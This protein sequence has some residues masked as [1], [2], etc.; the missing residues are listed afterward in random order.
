MRSLTTLLLLAGLASAQAADDTAGMFRRK[1][2]AV[3]R[4][5]AKAHLAMGTF[6]D[7]LRLFAAG[8]HDYLRAAQLDPSNAEAQAALGRKLVDGQWV[9]D[10]RVPAIVVNDL[11]SD[12][13][14]AMLAKYR[15]KKRV[16]GSEVAADYEKLADLAVDWGLTVEARAMWETMLRYEPNNPRAQAKLGYRKMAG[17]WISAAEGDARDAM[18]KRVL[19]APGG[20]VI[21]ATSE[22]EEK[23]GWTMAKRRTE[24]FSFEGQ[25]T[26]GE[27][28]ALVRTAETTR[29]LFLEAFD[30]PKE[31][32][33]PFLT[34]ILVR[35]QGDHRTF[36]EKCTEA[37]ELE[38]KAAEDLP[39]WEDRDPE[40]VE[41]WLGERPFDVL[42]DEVVH[43]VARSEFRDLAR[44]EK[45]PAWLAEG[46]A[47]WFGD[48]IL[49][50]AQASMD[51]AV[52]RE[53][54]STHT[55]L[56]WRSL[57]R[58]WTWEGTVP[59][60]R[61]I[62]RAPPGEL[63]FEM[64]VKAWSLV[65]WLMTTKRARLYDFLARCRSG[66]SGKALRKAL[67]A[68]DYDALEAMWEEW[69]QP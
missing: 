13:L 20:K 3:E 56:K 47:A 9:A 33:P 12:Y 45:T 38:R 16:M 66:S 24:N 53:L 18:A 19:E 8:R 17:V 25:F 67:G 54:R 44:M 34:V 7:G 37:G 64:T 55:T 41:V 10:P 32:H 65:D 35:H 26:D 48:R 40:R 14:G 28:R 68:K 29:A 6:A 60:I 63:T 46:V 58:E 49:G 23:T 27:V 50:S 31:T 36:L 52:V 22:V 62:T 5:T 43:S 11:K 1:L 4:R 61:D 21:D 57:L 42:R 2:A 30:V 59:S 39:T 69:I 15:G 51:R